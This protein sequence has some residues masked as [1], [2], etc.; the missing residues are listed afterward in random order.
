MS[1]TISISESRMHP[2]QYIPLILCLYTCIDLDQPCILTFKGGRRNISLLTFEHLHGCQASIWASIHTVSSVYEVQTLI[3]GGCSFIH[4]HGH[5]F[6]RLW[7]IYMWVQ[8]SKGIVMS[9]ILVGFVCVYNYMYI[10]MQ[11]LITH[12]AWS[13]GHSQLFNVAHRNT[14]S[15][16]A[17]DKATL[18]HMQYLY[19]VCAHATTISG[20]A[21]FLIMPCGTPCYS[22]CTLRLSYSPTLLCGAL[23]TP[24]YLKFI[25]KY[26]PLWYPLHSV[27][28]R[29]SL[30]IFLVVLI[31]P[32][33][34]LHL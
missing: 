7:Y 29:V 3:Q 23:C 5:S 13:Q 12:L 30:Y 14:K 33:T 1:L 11:V 25:T 18:I 10:H 8:R 28:P 22:C 20:S 27:V 15:G 34:Y 32:D 19:L 2:P 26:S 31:L 16:L 21:S 4:V 9:L 6:T 24:L 17:R